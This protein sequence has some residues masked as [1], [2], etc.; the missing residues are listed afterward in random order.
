MLSSLTTLRF[1]SGMRN[2]SSRYTL[3][4]RLPKELVK[5]RM[6]HSCVMQH[7]TGGIWALSGELSSIVILHEALVVTESCGWAGPSTLMS[8]LL[9]FSFLSE[10]LWASLTTLTRS[11]R[12][13]WGRLLGS[14]VLAGALDGSGVTSRASLGRFE[15]RS[16]WP[17]STPLTPSLLRRGCATSA[18]RETPWLQ[19]RDRNGCRRLGGVDRVIMGCAVKDRIARRV[20]CGGAHSIT[21]RWRNERRGA[22][23][24]AVVVRSRLPCGEGRPE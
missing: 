1:F 2:G 24:Q 20:S 23:S 5:V 21:R 6:V 7:T 10:I 18:E 3:A 11:E 22:R 4:T 8:V 19:F 15:G 16:S 17:W 12:G 9:S 14:A 13:A